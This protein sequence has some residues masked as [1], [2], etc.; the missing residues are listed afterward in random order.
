VFLP[1]VLSC[2]LCG[3]L[4]SMNFFLFLLSGALFFSFCSVIVLFSRTK[5]LEE[6]IKKL[7]AQVEKLLENQ[8][9][10]LPVETV[11]LVETAPP[12]EAAQERANRLTEAIVS[13][14]RGGNLWAAGG[15]VLLTAGFAAL[16]TYLARRGFFTADMGIAA[17]AFAGLF[18]ILF[19]WRFRRKRPV[20]FLILQGGG[21]GILYLSVYA[22]HKFTS[23]FSAPLSLALMTLL[24]PPMVILAL[25]QNAQVIAVLAFMG[26]FATP[27]LL[28][29]VSENHLFLFCYYLVLNA[30]VLAI[31][32]FRR[33]KGL[34]LAAFFFTFAV[35]LFWT[36]AKYRP[37][38]FFSSEPFILAYIITF[39]VLGLW[40]LKN[41][42]YRFQHYSDIILI[43]GTPVAAAA[44]QCKIFSFIA[45]GYAIIALEFSVFYLLLA[46]LIS[47]MNEKLSLRKNEACQAEDAK[48]NPLVWIIAIW[49]FAWWFGGWHYE[50]SQIFSAPGGAFLIL[51]S[52]S[53]V[54]FWAAAAFFNLKFFIAGMVPAPITAAV[55]VIAVF[56]GD[57]FNY[58][59]GKPI[60][61]Y[62]FFDFSRINSW[63]VF[64]ILQAVS[65]FFLKPR[66][67]EDVVRIKY[68]TQEPV[69]FQD[70]R[71]FIVILTALAVFS[72]SGR[73]Y[74]IGLGFSE[75]WVSFAGLF[76]VF[77]ALVILPF[78]KRKLL[79]FVLPLL[80]SGVLGL[81]FIIS[82]FRSGDPSPL[83]F[84]LPVINLLDLLEGI[85]I[86]CA[87]SW[88]I[89][90]KDKIPP[91]GKRALFAAED[92]LVFL[93]IV[94]ILA[95]SVHNFADLPWRGVP[96]SDEFQLCLLVFWALYGIL[97]IVT[98]NQKKSRALWISG[99]VLVTADIA[100]LIL[101]D[102]RGIGAVPRI[103]SFFGA[104]I[105]LLFIGWAAPL[106]PIPEE[107]L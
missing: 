85:C 103:L 67:A 37:E 28:S 61:S 46:V 10:D 88:R 24:I 66:A 62:N 38:F 2:D 60:F 30:G 91:K 49:G 100:K 35:S 106:P 39:T 26:G 73:V 41:Q 102:M 33:W 55:T 29:S 4:S 72:A 11:P 56:C 31:G 7:R 27:L 86:L 75:S 50:L 58:S 87:L 53:A 93:W 107:K 97:H 92:V 21:L 52:L 15:V 34:N 12:P 90:I 36:M 16:I 95:R 79:F 104:G 84:Y 32:Y 65:F 25:F 57:I 81:W 96:A 14:V 63:A 20:Y 98:G 40:G 69:R 13:F 45:H 9:P 8:K 19:G 44:I 74:A 71:L 48:Q 47:K 83:P 18:M 22:A 82:L 42:E 5:H 94:S 89:R 99:A 6:N 43:L 1:S 51:A 80:L 78:G 17:A 76:P 3:F 23:H 77:A 54:I 59:S 70:A 105:V 64:F 101:F 68:Q